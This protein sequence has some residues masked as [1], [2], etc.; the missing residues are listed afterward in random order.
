MESPRNTLAHLLKRPVLFNYA[1]L[2]LGAILPCAFIFYLALSTSYLPDN[3]YWSAMSTMIVD[4]KFSAN[5]SNLM[6]RSNEHIIAIPKLVY[7]LN[8]Y[9]TAG[10]NTGLAIFVWIIAT[11]QLLIIFSFI[12]H[13][14]ARNFLV[15]L[16]TGFVVSSFVYTSAAAHNW[17]YG[18]SGAAWVT[19]NFFSICAI[20]SL[21][22][23]TSKHSLSYAIISGTFACMGALSYSSS[24]AVFPALVILC[25]MLN[26][27]I[28]IK[29]FFISLSGIVF[30]LY[31]IS[32][33]APP[34][35]PPAETSFESI[36]FYSVAFLG[37]IFNTSLTKATFWGGVGMTL[38]AAALCIEFMTPNRKTSNAVWICIAIYVL[39]NA[40]MAGISRS[41]FGFTASSRYATLPALFWLSLFMLY[42]NATLLSLDRRTRSFYVLPLIISGLLVLKMSDLGLDTSK[43]LLEREKKKSLAAISIVTTAYDLDLIKS[44]VTPAFVHQLK[45]YLGAYK[46]FGHLP[47]S[48]PFTNCPDVEEVI[49]PATN[50][51]IE[52]APNWSGHFDGMK[53]KSESSV[54]IYGWAYSQHHT[55]ECVV[56][57]NHENSVK[58]FALINHLRPDVAVHFGKKSLN[59]GWEGYLVFEE[60]T[61]YHAYVK[62]KGIEKWFPFREQVTHRPL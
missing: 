13:G 41:G 60:E 11:A 5:M 50:S 43:R 6:V 7:L 26:A 35:H 16:V 47:F 24:L 54:Y 38:F 33:P 36:F 15:S 20:S 51:N 62:F 19:S 32:M 21:K 48:T 34:N 9:L 29:V 14:T 3:D 39:A 53:F 10:S 31:L 23:S 22:L 27:K 56:V 58:G 52:N 2:V 57:V 40:S 28:S 49:E 42:T 55:V 25:F 1:P 17:I 44:S 45:P 61:S 12:D 4:G 59:S 8:A 46:N 18:M 37:G 30:A